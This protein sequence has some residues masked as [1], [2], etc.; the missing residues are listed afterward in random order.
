[1]EEQREY[2]TPIYTRKAYERYYEKNKQNEE[3]KAKRRLAAK[4][5]YQKKKQLK[6]LEQQLENETES[7]NAESE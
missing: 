5:Y 6:L 2:K 3:F 7:S 4:K 1:M